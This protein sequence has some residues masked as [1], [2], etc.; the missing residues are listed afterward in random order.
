MLGA[1]DDKV[2]KVRKLAVGALSKVSVGPTLCT[3]FVPQTPWIL[4]HPVD[5]FWQVVSAS[6][7][8][9]R[10]RGRAGGRAGVVVCA[11]R[12]RGGCLRC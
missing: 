6:I 2:A 8:G 12:G 5:A 10:P 7:G 11:C 9:C 1:L 4:K 3:K